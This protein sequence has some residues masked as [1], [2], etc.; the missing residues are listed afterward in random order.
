VI[1]R[2]DGKVFHCR[3]DSTSVVRFD[4]S[5]IDPLSDGYELVVDLLAIRYRDAGTD[6]LSPARRADR[7]CSGIAG[8]HRRRWKADA[9]MPP[10]VVSGRRHGSAKI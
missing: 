5:D 6:A 2:S 9:L 10:G 7:A 1:T 4:A 8:E 3:A